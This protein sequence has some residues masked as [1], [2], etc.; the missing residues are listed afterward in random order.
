M[1]LDEVPAAAWNAFGEADAVVV[2]S[3]DFAS[4]TDDA[5]AQSAAVRERIGP[6]PLLVLTLASK[7]YLLDDPDADSV[8]ATVPRNVVDGVPMVG[9]GDTFGA[10]LAI[11]L[12]RGA[13]PAGAAEAATERVIAVLESRRG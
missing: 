2:S 6:R 8:T 11:N 1:R 12:A 13:T 7:G 9:A 4:D 10:A 3:E 5:F